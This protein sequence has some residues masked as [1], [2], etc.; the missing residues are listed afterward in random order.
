MAIPKPSNENQGSNGTFPF[1]KA[2]NL[3]KKGKAK[4]TLIGNVRMMD[5]R[6]GEQLVVDVKFGVKMYAWSIKLNSGNHSR[7]FD[8]FGANEKK[9]KG[10]V[11]VERD[12]YL[13]NEY[14]KV[15]D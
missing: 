4:L 6:F 15:S 3:P 11:T 5:G 13:G 12:E 1:L 14:V 8:R 7:L 10:T 9:W 2:S